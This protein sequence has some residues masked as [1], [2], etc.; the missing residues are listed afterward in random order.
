[1]LVP[2]KLYATY[3]LMNESLNLVYQLLKKYRVDE[4]RKYVCVCMHTHTGGKTW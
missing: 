2:L 3:M 4:I 1:M